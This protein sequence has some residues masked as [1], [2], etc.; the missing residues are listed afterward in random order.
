MTAWF[1]RTFAAPTPAQAQ[2]WPLVEAGHHVLVISPTGTGKTLSA[3]LAVL[4]R[5]A[6]EA[7]AGALE[8]GIQALYVSPL[9]AL[10]YDLE[11]NLRRPLLEAYG[12]SP[13]IEVGLRS[14]DTPAADRQRQA[15]K[16]PH[17]LLT[18]PESLLILLSQA[19]WLP[20]L[21][22]VRWVIVDELHALAENKRGTHLSLSLERLEMLASATRAVSG[23]SHAVQRI[24]LSATVAPVDRLA[25]FLVGE[26]RECRVVDAA[27]DKR[28][29]M[30]VHS[31][32][33]DD[34]YPAA[35]HT[36]QRLIGDLA[37]LVD[38]HRTTLVFCNTRSG[39]EMV[40]YGLRTL[41]PKLAEGIEC[42]HA[43]LERDVRLEVEDRLKRG[44]LRA[45]VCS[46]S[47]ELG[48]D[49]GSIDLVVMWG[50]PKGV[51]RALQRT[52]RAGHQ[53]GSVSRGLLMATNVNDL[54]EACATAR[55]ARARHLDG[56]RLP[57]GPLDVLA[58]HL[59]GMGCVAR[60]NRRD[61]YALVRRAH[62]YRLLTEADFD[63]VLDYLAGGGQ[64]LRRRY[65]EVFGKIELDDE[66]FVTRSGRVQRDYLQN[67]G[68][69]PSE[70][71]VLVRLGMRGL[72]S[73]EESFMRGVRVG[74]VFMLGG[75][76]VRLVRSAPLEAVVERADG[77][78]PTVP[79]WNANKMPLSNR[80]AADIVDFRSALRERFERLG[81]ELETHL[82]WVAGRLECDA[83]NASVIL[84]THRVQHRLSEIP[85]AAT[86]L[87]EEWESDGSEAEPAAET[88]EPVAAA[89]GR[90]RSRRAVESMR[91]V[92]PARH[93]FVHSLIGR[94][95]N[96]ALAR[97]VALRLGRLRA[98]NAISTP[99]DYGF[100]LTVSRDQRI[101]EA[102]V[103]ALLT[104]EGF[105]SDLR[106]GLERSDLLKYH[107]RGAAQT[108]LMVYRNFFGQ[109]K[110]V[111]K[112]QWSA[113]VIFNV[114][115]EYEPEHVLL[116]EARR[117]ATH[118]FLDL[119]GAVAFLE[120]LSARHRGARAHDG[121]VLPAWRVRRL[122]RVPPLSFGMYA[123]RIR[124]ALL[125]EDPRETLERLFHQW[126]RGMDDPPDSRAC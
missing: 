99:D 29:E 12:G 123:S 72:G 14:G 45:V 9:R 114:L 80:V 115:V 86:L 69:I 5:L 63:A 65:A 124:E 51:S 125:V 101:T 85:T 82:D 1:R 120:D 37:Q 66:G 102:D 54:V 117:E 57:E 58:Q 121:E 105:E 31:P 8:P 49:I 89:K 52:G 34:P 32:L 104:P 53:W 79:R 43:S 41:L 118:S 97:V 42:H 81:P 67:A 88:A 11:K 16:P 39:A 24:G 90:E 50:T 87:I 27:V 107:F 60:W 26:G 61:A 28:L 6:V 3:F 13:P 47:L 113:E 108:G 19:R 83:R 56:V 38:R 25:R 91:A 75:R 106:A 73:V 95:A 74:D 22:R 15:R 100:V 21:G 77:A 2:A 55:L 93:Y 112:L 116:R 44:E 17:L 70:G 126:W 36:G 111:R 92:Q 122:E 18:T 110:A 64:A 7:A 48:I 96:D 84:R 10:G 46:T 71:S 23:R 94:P 30:G 98:G 103:G 119:P 20:A 35:G 109:Q 76:P 68:V 78:V 40:T 59:V 62:A 33:D 4:H